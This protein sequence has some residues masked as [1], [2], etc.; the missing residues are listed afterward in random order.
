M[1][2]QRKEFYRE[3][4]AKCKNGSS[5]SGWLQDAE[6][7]LVDVEIGMI[8][9]KVRGEGWRQGEFRVFKK[10]A[11]GFGRVKKH[12][13]LTPEVVKDVLYAE[14]TMSTSHMSF[15]AADVVL[16]LGLYGELKYCE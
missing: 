7:F 5:A 1:P 3:V 4:L 11:E 12:G 9:E 8:C 6:R 15:E 14:H 10:I 16:Q 2:K 13:G